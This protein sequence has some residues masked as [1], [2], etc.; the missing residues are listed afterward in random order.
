MSNWNW[1]IPCSL[2]II[3]YFGMIWLIIAQDMSYEINL[4]MDNNTL[5]AIKHIENVSANVEDINFNI[6]YC[7][8][9]QNKS[10]NSEGEE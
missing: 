8:V 2:L 3:G 9:S 4:N 6:Y 10:V 7:N 1:V 5:E